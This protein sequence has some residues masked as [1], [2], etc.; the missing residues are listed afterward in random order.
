MEDNNPFSTSSG[1]SYFIITPLGRV[2][3]YEIC[4]FVEMVDYLL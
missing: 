4:L 2:S 1:R 3:L